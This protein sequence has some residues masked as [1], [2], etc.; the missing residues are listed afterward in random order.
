[1]AEGKLIVLA[2]VVVVVAAAL[3]RPPS[4]RRGG[5][6]RTLIELSARLSVR[7][8]TF[9]RRRSG[10]G[11]V[12]E[13]AHVWWAPV[14][15]MCQSGTACGGRYAV[16]P[17]PGTKPCVRAVSPAEADH[18]MDVDTLTLPHMAHGEADCT[19]EGS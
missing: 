14:A 10:R 9:L 17:L 13:R 16:W 8:G 7:A 15:S 11:C 4:C 2:L 12:P 3:H 1:M 18:L 6:G 19:V 5:S